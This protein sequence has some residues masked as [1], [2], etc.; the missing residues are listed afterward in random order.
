MFADKKGPGLNQGDSVLVSEPAP[1]ELLE[2]TADVESGDVACMCCVNV[3]SFP[4][5]LPRA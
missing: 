4:M 1:F 5:P 3:V 2:R